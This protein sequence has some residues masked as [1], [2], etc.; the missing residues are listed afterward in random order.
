MTNEIY[1]L[2]D[3]SGQMKKCS[4]SLERAVNYF[5]KN[6]FSDEMWNGLFIA[7]TTTREKIFKANGWNVMRGTFTPIEEQ[8]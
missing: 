7:N 1:A 2:F 8:K 6:V 4:D 5:P 3:P